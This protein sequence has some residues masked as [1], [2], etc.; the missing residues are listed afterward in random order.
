MKIREGESPIKGGGLLYMI[1]GGIS[2]AYHSQTGIGGYTFIFNSRYL[3]LA[4]HKP[5]E[6][7]EGGDCPIELSPVVQV[8]EVMKKRVLVA[9]TD[10]GLEIIEKIKELKIL[11]KTYR[12]GYLKEQQKL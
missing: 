1:D 5:F 10:E 8:V 4:E 6:P 7:S 3:A 12:N 9:D 2:K 11:L